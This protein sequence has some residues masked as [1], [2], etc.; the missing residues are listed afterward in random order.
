MPIIEIAENQAVQRCACCGRCRGL[1]PDDLR[2]TDEAGDVLALPACSC[3]SVEFLIG[4]PK[5]EPEHPAPGSFGHRHRL[6][7]DALVDAV[8][9]RAKGELG[10][11]L[12]TVVADRI[13]PK[14]LGKWFPDGLRV[15]SEESAPDGPG[16]T[17]ATTNHG[18]R[19]D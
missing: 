6:V 8:R 11:S 4:A 9:L 1:G 14:E 3:G 5:D 15:E 2:P 7:V 12:G 10:S 13:G 18:G 17:T 19:N 16:Q